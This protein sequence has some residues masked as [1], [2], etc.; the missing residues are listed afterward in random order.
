[1]DSW[2]VPVGIVIKDK[3]RLEEGNLWWEVL[4]EPLEMVAGGELSM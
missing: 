2:D 1:M 3:A 4:W